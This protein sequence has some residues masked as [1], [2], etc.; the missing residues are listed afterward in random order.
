MAYLLET[1]KISVHP[2]RDIVL[3]SLSDYVS[4]NLQK[5]EGV[6]SHSIFQNTLVQN[7]FFFGQHT[8]ASGFWKFNRKP[9]KPSKL[10]I[11]HAGQVLDPCQSP[12]AGLPAFGQHF[13][14]KGN[15]KSQ[16]KTWPLKSGSYLSKKTVFSLCWTV[17]I[18]KH[19]IPS[20]NLGDNP[21]A[22]GEG[23]KIA[24]PKNGTKSFVRCKRT[25][26]LQ[27]RQM[28]PFSLAVP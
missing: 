21:Q 14:G 18:S 12:V 26:G 22:V 5:P 16:S 10:L 25:Q 9:P 3:R 23:W 2:N 15:L 13:E 24:P 8:E 17:V 11:L 4:W 6:L 19:W 27:N 28:M 1:P 7:R 20:K